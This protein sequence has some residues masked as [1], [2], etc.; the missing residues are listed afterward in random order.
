MPAKS[1]ANAKG[2][3]AGFMNFIREQGVVGLAVGLAIGTAAGDTVK[4]LVGAFIDPLVQLIVGSQA[5]LKA[6]EFTLK[7]GDRE[8]VFAWGAFVSSLITLLAVAFV[9]YAIVHLMK[10]DK[11]DKSKDK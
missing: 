10:L 6:A 9:V 11:L 1:V 8:G 3:S 5:G 2:H 7:V 4:Q